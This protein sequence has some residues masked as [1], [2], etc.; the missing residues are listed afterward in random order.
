MKKVLFI[1][2]LIASVF[3]SVNVEAQCTRTSS[4]GS[5][6]ASATC[7]TTVTL[8]TCNYATEYATISS[9]VAGRTYRV[10]S[11]VATDWVTIRHTTAAGTVVSFAVQGTNWVAPVSGTYYAHFST[12]STCGTNTTCRTTSV[13]TVSGCTAPS[14]CSNTSSFGSA[15]INTAGTAVTISTCSYA[16]E[17]STISGAVSGQTL[18]FTSSVATDYITIR[19]GSPTGTIVAQGTT[20]LQF[21]NTFTGTLYAHWNTNSACGTQNTC[22]TTT[23]QCMS[24]TPPPPSVANDNC[25]GATAL[26]C[27]STATVN[28]ANATTDAAGSNLCGTTITTPGVWYAITGNGQNMTVSTVGLTSVDT[29]LMVFS[30]SCAALTCVGGNDD[31]GGLQSSVSWASV[32]GTTYYVLA[33]AYTGTASFPMSLTCTTPVVDPCASITNLTCG[34]NSSYTVAAGTGVWNN[35]GGPFL[36]PGTER[37]FSYTPATSGTIDISVSSSG[38]YVDL[39][40]KTGSCGSTGWTYL[41]DIFSTAEVSTMTVT[42]GT[43]YFFLLDGETTSAASGV[44]NVS[45]PQQVFDPCTSIPT[46]SSCTGSA[47]S[48]SIASGNGAWILGPYSSVGKE[49]IYSFTPT[50]TAAYNITVVNNGASSWVDLFWKPASAGCNGT[51]WTYVNDNYLGTENQTVTFTAGVT[52]YIMLDPEATTGATGSIQI[53]CP[54]SDGDGVTDN[55][56]AC[57]TVFG[58][59]SNGCPCIGS[60]VD[61]TYNYS[62]PITIQGTTV[63]ACDNSSLRAGY[64]RIYAVNISCPGTYTF[65]LCNGATWDTY[66]TL[67][68]ASGSGLLATNDD[69]CGLQS[70]ITYT[71]ATAGT[72]YIAVEPYSSTTTGAF[73]LNISGTGSVPSLSGAVTNVSCNGGSNGGVNVTAASGSAVTYAWSNGATTEDISGVSAGTYTLTATNCWGSSTQTFTVAQPSAI[74]VGVS[75]AASTLCVEGETTLSGTISG[76]AGTLNYGWEFYDENGGTWVNISS[77]QGISPVSETISTGPLPATAMFRLVATDAID[78]SCSANA[79]VTITV[80]DDPVLSLSI[81]DY[82]GYGVSC[83]GSTDGSINSTLTG[84]LPV[85]YAYAWSNGANTTDLANIGAGNYLLDVSGD[86]GCNASASADI[87]EADALVASS[88]STDILCNGGTSDVTVSATGGVLSYSGDGNYT[89]SAGTYSYTVTDANGCASTTSITVTEPSALTAIMGN[90]DYNGYGV[91]CFGSTDGFAFAHAEGGTPNYTYSWSNGA[92]VSDLSGLAAGTYNV[93]VTDANGCIFN[94]QVVLVQPTKVNISATNTA[95]LCNGGTSDVTVSTWGGVLPYSADDAGSYTVTAGSYDYSVV[96]ANGCSASTNVTISEPT[97]L[98]ASSTA[99]DILCNGGTSTITV[100][101]AGGT[102]AYSGDGNY[103]VTA[104]TYSYTVTDANGCTAETSI[105][106]TEPTALTSTVSG[107]NYNGYGVSCFGSTDG[108]VTTA[109]VGGTPG[110]TYSWSNGAITSDISGLGAGSYS[111]VI[112]DANGCT[113]SDGVVLVEPTRV[114]IGATYTDILCYGQ[115]S[116]I[117]VVTSGGVTPYVVDDA[118]SYAEPAGTYTYNVVD[119]N[120]CSASTSISISQPTQLT[121]N[122]G[123]DEIVFYGYGPMSCANLDADAAGGTPNYSIIWTSLSSGGGVGEA[124]TACPTVNEVYTVT[125]TDANGCTATDELS[126]CVVDVHCEVGNSGQMNVE[127]CMIPPGNPGNAHTI[128]IDENAVPAHLALG[129]VLGA[130]GEL[131]NACSNASAKNIDVTTPQAAV[132]VAPNPT[133]NNTTVSI[134]MTVAG[135]YSVVLYDMMGKAVQTVFNGSLNKMENNSLDRK[136][137]V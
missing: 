3:A 10:N 134:T 135:D 52:Y 68:S 78:Q 29:K 85:N 127:I 70:S 90:S 9:V 27:G 42:A 57:P 7:G 4:F 102:P 38:S 5:G 93:T 56:D 20:P 69:F 33:A 116:N 16:G 80:V 15:T 118:G 114:E 95:I 103:T 133:T 96:D 130:C 124:I 49:Q 136:S 25:S 6:T 119:L 32:S 26:T 109:T 83:N 60:A 61:G 128:C 129:A 59:L 21:N 54:D 101:A 37:V 98:T 14:G 100:S 12:N 121:V 67:S 131:E 58:T 125:V 50:T 19:S 97:L 17:Y 108:S 123:G 2:S 39:Y 77:N 110:Y 47:T 41:N 28:T 11:S 106:V 94:E 43:T 23:V 24:C 87:I 81:S 122:A 13:T 30:G 40:W 82:N 79:E 84:G 111:V 71:V 35:L 18:R 113:Y 105:V 86:L 132:T 63:D 120:G 107:S 112:T 66:L 44:I 31:S 22:R 45:C 62:T 74:T 137:V 89:V 99:T 36:T 115:L 1:L 73:T 75:A 104:G 72:Y 51:G 88:T 55:V 91:S 117:N 8:S 76:G 64:D 34:V 126:I 65:S 92:T 46:L 53:Q 48:Y